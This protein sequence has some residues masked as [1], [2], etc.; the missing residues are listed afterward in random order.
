MKVVDKDFED[1]LQDEGVVIS[2]SDGRFELIFRCPQCNEVH[3]SATGNHIYNPQT[4]S[5][6]PSII[7]PCGFHKT[8]RGGY[9]T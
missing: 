8:L 6:T 1:L 3:A 7:C 9:W 5:I 2:R 4:N